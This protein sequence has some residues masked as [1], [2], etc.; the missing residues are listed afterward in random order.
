MLRILVV[1]DERTIANYIAELLSEN[2][3]HVLPLYTPEDALEHSNHF[4]FDLAVVGIIM[5][6][7]NGLGLADRLRRIIPDCR[8]S[9]S[10][11]ILP[12]VLQV[13]ECG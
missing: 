3:Y 11:R 10:V 4:H 13:C 2:G 5:P 9:V 6:G 12:C 1:D 7:L 8:I